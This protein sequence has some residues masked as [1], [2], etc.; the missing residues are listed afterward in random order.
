LAATLLI[1]SQIS[2]LNLKF[3]IA[4]AELAANF[5]TVTRLQFIER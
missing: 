3:E 5:D 1:Q 2:D 4:A